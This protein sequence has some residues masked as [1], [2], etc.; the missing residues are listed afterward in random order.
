M[1]EN[2]LKRAQ[3]NPAEIFL[4]SLKE[5]YTEIQL[6]V[7]SVNNWVHWLHNALGYTSSSLLIERQNQFPYEILKIKYMCK[8]T[9][10]TSY[11]VSQQILTGFR[12]KESIVSVIRVWAKGVVFLQSGVGD[13]MAQLCPT[14][15]YNNTQHGAALILIQ[16]KYFHNLQNTSNT[17]IWRTQRLKKSC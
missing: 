6:L 13:C 8:K 7:S 3:V 2:W 14:L 12:W 10:W 11:S 17:L 4:Y 1:R 5:V 9:F 15:R 16:N